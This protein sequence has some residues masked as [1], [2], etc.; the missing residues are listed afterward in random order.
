MPRTNR[1]LSFAGAG[2]MAAL[3]F[4]PANALAGGKIVTTG[5]AAIDDVFAPAAGIITDLEAS[6]KK[7]ELSRKKIRKALGAKE[8]ADM[9]A[10]VEKFAK[11][12]AGKI[13]VTMVKKE[14]QLVDKEKLA[15]M[16]A[17]ADAAKAKAG[18]GGKPGKKKKG[19]KMMSKLKSKA[20]AAPTSVKIPF[21]ELTVAKGAPSSVTAAV[22][23]INEALDGTIDVMTTVMSIPGKL[24]ATIAQATLLPIKAPKQI[25]EAGL[26]KEAGKKVMTGLKANVKV[27]AGLPKEA[28]AAGKEV[29]ELMAVVSGIAGGAA[30][31]GAEAA[32]DAAAKAKKK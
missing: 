32:K 28:I 30:K 13:S 4:A 2:F 18:K 3:A 20:G 16:K 5:I 29:K 7:L 6:K 15:E 14:I 17:K 24:Q 8:G 10:A 11:K 26:S 1:F 25:K 23:A 19:G 12:A 22:K 31:A 21:P 27:V 9:T